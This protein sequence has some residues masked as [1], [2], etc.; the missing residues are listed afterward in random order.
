MFFKLS[1][2]NMRRSIKDYAV[3][4]LTLMLAVCIFYM[5]N[6]IEAQQTMFDISQA[7]STIFQSLTI[8]M[9]IVS[10][11]V[12]A[13]LAFLII[14]ANKFMIK[15]RKKEFGIYMT[16]GMP[17]RRISMMLVTETLLI[18][19][20]ALA[21]G[22]VLGILASQ[23][24]AV[25]SAKMFDV[26]IVNYHFVFS[27]DAFKKTLFGF[28]IIFI[29][30]ILFNTRAITRLKL[31]D[32]L[33]DEH[34][35]EVLKV[36][37]KSTT[38]IFFIVG[39][40]LI[41]ASYYCVLAPGVANI[42]VTLGPGLL[43]NTVGTLFLFASIS[44]F[45]LAVTQRNKRKY[46]KGLTMFTMRQM[47]SKVNSN[48][49]SMTFICEMLFLTITILSTVTSVNSATHESINKFAPYDA[50][51]TIHQ[52]E[53]PSGRT[54]GEVLPELGIVED[55]FFSDHYEYSTYA[56]GL[57]VR[58]IATLSSDS[59]ISQTVIDEAN[60]SQIEAIRLSDFNAL[61][62]LQGAEPM[63]LGENQ[64]GVVSTMSDMVQ[65]GL[66]T[67]AA[68]PHPITVAGREMAFA[69]NSVRDNGLWTSLAGYTYLML[70]I[71]D[72]IAGSL[73]K[74][75]DIYVAEYSDNTAQSDDF[76]YTLLRDKASKDDAS[77]LEAFQ[78]NTGISVK[79][80][81]RA[82][83]TAANSGITTMLVFVGIY[84][85][86]IFLIAAAAILALQQLSEASDSKH[87]FNLLRQIGTNEK[88]I[89]Q[90]L[91]SQVGT[92]FMLPLILALIHSIAGISVMNSGI[93]IIGGIDVLY[94]AGITAILMAVVYGG[95]FLATYFGCRNI[96]NAKPGRVD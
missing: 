5:F 38:V 58:D 81:S 11:F 51:F 37:K 49:V 59:M 62:A 48:F 27:E 64:F 29:V 70:V 1:F 4:F 20:L 15:R 9:F 25:V 65:N 41:A 36:R 17:Q 8:V 12:A 95:Y 79:Y 2:Q 24:M 6:A 54:V 90:A 92:Y 91:F 60:N 50:S 44:G 68:N 13:V 32:L 87:R 94:A 69:Q 74:Q 33:N 10:F 21:A 96:I 39:V 57:T 26:A 23:G 85:G 53:N 71:P 63:T 84:M 66:E 86:I 35:N 52:T 80:A 19:L 18:G 31:I 34:K 77:G 67:Y 43:L 16:L 40:F 76:L 88:M 7:H 75:L 28:G 73:P 89:S 83:V 30:V 55:Q 78:T 82:D 72:D 45:M 14:Y 46:F 61:M 3:Y 56:T 42:T 47:N 93:N 22:L